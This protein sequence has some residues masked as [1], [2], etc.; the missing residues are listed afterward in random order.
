MRAARRP[1]ESGFNASPKG[2]TSRS[3]SAWRGT[4]YWSSIAAVTRWS[5][6]T[7][8]IKADRY[9]CV[10]N[11]WGVT[12][13]YHEYAYNLRPMPQAICVA[14]IYRSAKG[15][16]RRFRT[17]CIV[18]RDAG[19]K[20]GPSPSAC[21]PNG[22]GRNNSGTSSSPTIRQL[23]P[24]CPLF[25]VEPGDYLGVPMSLPWARRF[26]AKARRG[27]KRKLPAR[28]VSATTSSPS[29]RPTFNATPRRQVRAVCRADFRRMTKG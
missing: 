14:P 7:E 15:S 27:A 20:G 17:G 22:I 6:P 19:R 16:R 4:K 10:T 23:V 9:E 18:A 2:C 29:R 11:E 24:A 13:N 3:G 21:R 5:I 1:G 8:T 26:P 12:G 25:H 28:L